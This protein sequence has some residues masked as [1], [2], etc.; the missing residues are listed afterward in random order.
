MGFRLRTEI[1]PDGENEILLR[2]QNAEEVMNMQKELARLLKGNA[3]MPVNLDGREYFLPVSEI[4]FFESEERGVTVHTEKEMYYS[5]K[6]L[7]ELEQE[8]PYH[9]Y[10]VSK[11]CIL[12]ILKISSIDKNITGASTVFFY[13]SD[14]KAYVSRIYYKPLRQRIGEI[15]FGENE[16]G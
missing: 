8:L 16:K 15:R 10:R 7:Y 3:E 5:D 11:S 1:S 2:G 13:G 9:F 6:R 12:N 14:K 4:L